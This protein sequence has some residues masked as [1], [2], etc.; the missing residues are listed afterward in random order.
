MRPTLYY[1]ARL[2]GIS[3]SGNEIRLVI[4]YRGEEIHLPADPGNAHQYDKRLKASG[5]E[6]GFIG[7]ARLVRRRSSGNHRPRTVYR[8]DAYSDQSLRRAFD[9]DDYEYLDNNHNLNCIGWRNEKN[10]D[11]F[12]APRGII[13]GESGRFVSDSTEKYQLAV[14]FEFIELA[15][16]MKTDPVTLLKQFIADAC[17]LQSSPELPRADGFSSRGNEAVRKARDYLRASWR[18]KKDFF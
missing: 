5:N 17:H 11:G 8:F 4:E 1:D 12:L 7:L 13:P 18:L 15:T 3:Q 14:P 6:A 2:K 16:R 9:L 10:P